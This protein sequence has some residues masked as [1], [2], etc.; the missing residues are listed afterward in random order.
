MCTRACLQQVHSTAG[1][2]HPPTFAAELSKQDD[3]GQREL[4]R[5]E[6]RMFNC[7]D[8]K[9][10]THTQNIHILT[11]P[12]VCIERMWDSED[13]MPMASV[14]GYSPSSRTYMFSVNCSPSYATQLTQTHTHICS[15]SPPVLSDHSMTCVYVVPYLPASTLQDLGVKSSSR[16][17][18]VSSRASSLPWKSGS[19]YK[20]T[21]SAHPIILSTQPLTY[22]FI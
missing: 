11:C 13:R 7:S 22:W 16:V 20:W 15:M 12:A 9:W 19:E 5:H 17:A 18:V 14:L 1:E 2:H 3:G 21:C 4:L 10:H 6:N 8:W